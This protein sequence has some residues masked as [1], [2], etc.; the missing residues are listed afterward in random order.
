MATPERGPRPIPAEPPAETARW[1]T[2]G[3]ALFEDFVYAGLGIL[4]AASAVALLI[5]AVWIFGGHLIGGT[6]ADNVVGLLDQL[7]LILMLVEVLYTV[8]V[9]L[10]EHTLAPEPFLVVGLIAAVRRV[11]VLTAEFPKLAELGEVAFRNAM[12]ELGLLTGVILALVMSLAILR[13][14]GVPRP[15]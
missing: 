12:V 2:R 8:Q 11:L 15:A 9:S 5:H 4:L 7:L 10:R 14:R 13:R 3:F 6:L 1:F